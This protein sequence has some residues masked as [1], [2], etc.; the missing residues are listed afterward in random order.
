MQ[1]K[2]KIFLL[3]LVFF[4]FIFSPALTLA[5][6]SGSS[7]DVGGNVTGA[8]LPTPGIVPGYVPFSIS[9]TLVKE[10]STNSAIV[11]WET[12]EEA[13]CKLFWGKSVDYESG[14]ILEE[15][16]NIDHS[17][18]IPDLLAN[19]TYHFRVSCQNKSGQEIET[20]DQKFITLALEEKISPPE[21]SFFESVSGDAQIELVWGNPASSSFKGIR[22]IRSTEKYPQT[23]FEKDLIY[24][25]SGTSFVDK[26]LTNGTTYYYSIF[27]YDKY[28]N[29]SLG[30]FVF[31]TP[32]IKG[33]KPE[34]VVQL[35]PQI[36]QIPPAITK[37]KRL[38][39]TDFV[40]FQEGKIQPFVGQVVSVKS[41][42]PFSVS[43]IGE[44]ISSE[45]KKIV[46]TVFQPNPLSINF[47]YDIVKKE[48]VAIDPSIDETGEYYFVVQV[49][50]E[51]GEV[52]A[53]VMGKIKVEQ[54]VL[55]PTP[56]APISWWGRVWAYLGKIYQKIIR[57]MGFL[58]NKAVNCFSF[59]P[60]FL[61]V[62]IILLIVIIL[63]RKK[64]S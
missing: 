54:A 48:F 61:V 9:G 32:Q 24:D 31:G 22:L 21:V 44:K 38:E 59:F 35:I 52:F 27:T 12:N 45:A 14:S 26:G 62:F 41:G 3:F 46:L 11:S 25:G 60:Q 34:E 30:S 47:Q 43:I 16:G 29:Y 13:I 7:V 51:N 57:W 49:I 55:K 50:N 15:K 40:F 18:T 64:D 42:E 23:P 4:L 10:V 39:L 20:L 33:A 19:T 8:P 53:F 37:G 2:T 17:T 5:V 63:K 58:A 28:G 6:G 36:P 1:T 56:K